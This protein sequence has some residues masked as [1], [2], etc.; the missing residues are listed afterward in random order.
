MSLVAFIALPA[1]A[2]EAGAPAGNRPVVAQLQSATP[3][4]A[5]M[6]ASGR[7]ATILLP[8]DRDQ[9]L[10]LLALVGPAVAIGVLTIV[11][12]TIT[13]RSLRQDMRRRRIVYR[14]RRH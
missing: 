14:P 13:F 11:G 1:V 6:I 7:S 2:Q 4:D 8:D 5:G 12:L 10:R 3:Y 9:P